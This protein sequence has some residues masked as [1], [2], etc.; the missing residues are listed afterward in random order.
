MDLRDL[1]YT[2][3]LAKHQNISQAAKELYISQPALTKFIMRQEEEL[4]IPVF[5]K[6]G[7]RLFLTDAG[8]E[9]L[10]YAEEM[11]QLKEKMD[12]HMEE[13]R[14]QQKSRLRI[15]IQE[16]MG[17]YLIPRLIPEYEKKYPN[18]TLEFIEGSSGSFPEKLMSG[19]VELAFC[20]KQYCTKDMEAAVIHREE[21]V[22]AMSPDNPLKESAVWKEGFQYPWIDL[23]LCKDQRFITLKPDHWPTKAMHEICRAAG[24]HPQ[25]IVTTENIETGMELVKQNY[26]IMILN[27]S[28]L[29][30]LSPQNDLISFSVGKDPFYHEPSILYMKN[31]FLPVYAKEFIRILKAVFTH[32]LLS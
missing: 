20:P 4:G 19:K 21:V 24:F 8:K 23:F 5:E 9:Y 27:T 2:I 31:T 17:R 15:A 25:N 22:L 16:V 11:I 10:R 7:Y 14:H 28:H 29:L 1:Y 6:K 18:I 32:D 13:L 26:G 30:L 12:S 3:A